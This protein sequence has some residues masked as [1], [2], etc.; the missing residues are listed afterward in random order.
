MQILILFITSSRQC[1]LFSSLALLPLPI[2]CLM[3]INTR[4]CYLG[5]RTS[6]EPALGGL[7]TGWE[8]AVAIASKKP[9]SPH[10][11]AS[12]M[13]SMSM[14]SGLSSRSLIFW[15]GGWDECGNRGRR[16]STSMFDVHLILFL[17]RSPAFGLYLAGI[18]RRVT[19]LSFPLQTLTVSQN[20]PA[21][22]QI[23]AVECP[24][25]RISQP[26]LKL[27]RWSCQQYP[28]M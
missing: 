21:R 13:S 7:R 5:P 12:R 4:A 19:D 25:A 11:R 22:V 28:T 17:A 18:S 20:I 2:Q 8:K 23:G 3:L 14:R 26:G 1:Y 9:S 16:C 27:V 10:G 6:R 24:R 15:I